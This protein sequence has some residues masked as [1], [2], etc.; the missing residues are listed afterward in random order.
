M[1]QWLAVPIMLMFLLSG[2]G[3]S[4]GDSPA[5]GG[6]VVPAST[7]SGTAAAGA[8]IIGQVTVKDSST[9]V[10]SKSAQIEAD[11]NYTID[12]T[13]MTPPFVLRAEGTVGGRTY[14]LHS[15]AQAADL[16]GTVNVTPFTDLIVANAAGQLASTLFDNGD[17]SSLTAAEVAAQE[18]ALQAKLQT[19]LTALG[20]D[21]AVDLLHTA[22]SADHTALDAALD[23]VRV[24]ID[25]VSI[26]ATITNLIDNTAIV[27]DLEST[28][29]NSAVL[30]V[31][32]DLASVQ[33]NQQ[34]IYTLLDNFSA[35][36]ASGLPSQAQLSPFL[37]D[38]F[39]QND[40]GKAQF[41]TDLSTD[42]SLVG[43]AL[44]HVVI[45]AL[46]ASAGTATVTF[47]VMFNEIVTPDTETWQ[48]V[49]SGNLWQLRGNQEIVDRWFD[50]ICDFNT[51]SDGASL[52]VCGINLGADD[53]DFTNNGT[54]GAPIASAKVT[55][56]RNDVPV[57]GGVVYMGIPVAGA[58][59]ELRIYDTDYSD[60]FI[61][62]GSGA[63]Q[64][65][66]TLIAVG[67][68]LQFELFTADLDLTNTSAPAVSGSP[69]ATYT[70]A[71]HALPVTDAA[72]AAYPSA[73][74]ATLAAF[75]AL[76]TAGGNLAIAWT[77]PTGQS[78]D[79]VALM[80]CDG[81]N[82]EDVWSE[83]NLS[84]TGVTLTID[85][86]GLNSA[87]APFS[88][89]LRIYTRDAQDRSFLR[90]Y[91]GSTATQTPAP[92]G[93]F[94]ASTVPG[95]YDMYFDGTWN[96]TVTFVNGGS[97]SIKF[98]PTDV[99]SISWSVDAGGNL[100]FIE[101]STPSSPGDSINHW[102]WTLSS[103][104]TTNGVNYAVYC[105][106]DNSIEED[107]GTT[108]N[109]TGTLVPATAGALGFTS[110]MLDTL[111]TVYIQ[112]P[113]DNPDNPVGTA[114]VQEIISMTG[115][116]GSY[117]VSFVV[118]YFDGSNA[119][120]ESASFGPFTFTLNQDGTLSAVITDPDGTAL[121]TW[122][123]TSDNG[124]SLTVFGEANSV[125]ADQANYDSWTNTW[126]L[127][128]PPANWLASP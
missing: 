88:T 105:H 69:V 8:A 48:L 16:G 22:F 83:E 74:P 51:Q 126:Y 20:V 92:T 121:T 52:K 78:I 120:I 112:Y 29:D 118:N 98:A 43:L 56:L 25:P 71:I 21:A 12:V 116:N 34:A 107:P 57:S 28:S 85:T 117:Q 65:D 64:F 2:C 77:V 40:D 44:S 96:S 90:T 106:P 7:L 11:G 73:T 49:R 26:Q 127:N 10:Q 93:G 19:V 14:K 84:G 89:E 46:D 9:P 94:E 110:Q 41:L 35:L 102:T 39:L 30:P 79:E 37:A 32:S 128:T 104:G 31:T 95:T 54:G 59:G 15:Y 53:L 5:G 6:P 75:D 109:F 123:L 36:F 63:M 38:D 111:S 18:T 87:N 33:A 97:G 27:D 58:A 42:P 125:P 108:F 100:V 13:G 115:S 47:N 86:S 76:T 50:Y 70:T 24:E 91:H 113:N 23:L 1:K 122:T 103:T 66:P 81:S 99:N 80:M 45:D 68:T 67:D 61:G 119:F 114:T 62:F 55:L 101:T 72:N 60:D 3:G 82:C 124:G 17:F 4:G